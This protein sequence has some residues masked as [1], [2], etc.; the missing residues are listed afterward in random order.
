MNTRDTVLAQ[1]A[2]FSAGLRAASKGRWTPQ[3]QQAADI[4][5]AREYPLTEQRPR[6]ATIGDR[7]YR[8]VEGRL[9]VRMTEHYIKFHRSQVQTRMREWRPAGHSRDSLFALVNLFDTPTE[10]MELPG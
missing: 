6:V 7:E 5:A 3:K 2:G 8:V 4:L 9:E 1:R 10:T